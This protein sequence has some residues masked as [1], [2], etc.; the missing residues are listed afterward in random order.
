MK[1]EEKERNCT[2]NH[3]WILQ[4]NYNYA[5]S[6]HLDTDKTVREKN[7]HIFKALHHTF[8]GMF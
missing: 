3:R 7:K 4:K 6:V 5:C 8:S 2:K 1:Y